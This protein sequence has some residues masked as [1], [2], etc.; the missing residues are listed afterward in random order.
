[1]AL[2]G[3][4]RD[5]GVADIFQL[6]GQQIKTGVLVFENDLDAVRVYFQEG[7]V[8]HGESATKDHDRM[9]GSLLVRAEAITQAQLDQAYTEQ[10]RT[11]Q[12][13]GQV[14]LDLNYV[15][16]A[17]LKEFAA[18]QLA[19][20]VYGLFEWTDGTYQFDAGDVPPSP[21]GVEP[22]RVE[23]IVLN[24]I[25]FIDEWPAIRERIPSNLWLVERTR[26]LPAAAGLAAE[27]DSS[28]VDSH[29][30]A[31]DVGEEERRVYDLVGA[32]RTVQKIVDL[33]RMG[34]F[35]TCQSLSTLMQAGY[36]R[37]IKPPPSMTDTSGIEPRSSLPRSARIV[38]RILV[39]AGLVIL[40]SYLLASTTI[41]V[42]GAGGVELGYRQDFVGERLAQTQIKVLRRALEVYR[43]QNGS[44]PLSLDELVAGG[45]VREH[46]TRYPF[47]QR[48]FYRVDESGVVVL[49]PP[50][51]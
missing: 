20:T 45:F 43:Y 23:T 27:W 25:R 31:E 5:F 50:V 19:E 33:S 21:E 17:V 14:L 38:G 49:R 48:Y 39:S 46:D 32:G 40:T 47:T 11:L 16:P 22:M 29:P 36:V 44:Y 6:V 34:E 24:G 37:V 28:V 51:R 26:A 1:M 2:K 8:V 18:L 41:Q 15:L 30:G 7:A 12:R 10:L 42:S 4:I 9:L 3:T 13:L 35:E